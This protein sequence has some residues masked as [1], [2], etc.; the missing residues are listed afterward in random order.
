MAVVG[1][2]DALIADLVASKAKMEPIP[3]LL[4]AMEWD[5]VRTILKTPPVNL[6]WNNGDVSTY[7]NTGTRLH[8]YH[9]C[10]IM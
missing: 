9:Y 4:E 8:M 5:A 6:L 3:S 2:K 7:Y 10:I 1:E